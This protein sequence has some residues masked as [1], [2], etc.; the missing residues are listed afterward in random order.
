MGMEPTPANFYKLV[1]NREEM[2]E[3]FCYCNRRADFYDFEVVAF[4]EKNEDEYLTVS[5]RGFTHFISGVPH[6][7]TATQWEREASIYR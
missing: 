4:P 1:A 5:K 2:S 3:F 6:F 7:I